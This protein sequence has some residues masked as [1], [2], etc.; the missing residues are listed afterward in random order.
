MT[1]KQTGSGIFMHAPE[2][3]SGL[4]RMSVTER[5]NLSRI[6]VLEK[7][8]FDR[9][10]RL[11]RAS[12][13]GIN[14]A[15]SDYKDVYAFFQEASKDY[16]SDL[17]NPYWAFTHDILKFILMKFITEHFRDARTTHVF[18]AG[19]GT[20]NWSRFV[21]SL[22]VSMHGIM[23]DMNANMLRVA[24][25]KL[26]QVHN[27]VRIVEG[28]LEV[29]SD[30]PSQRSNLVLCM[31]NVIGLGRNTELILHNL[32]TYLEDDGLAFIMAMNKYHAFNFTRQFRDET[33]VL[34]VVHDGTVKFKTDMPEIFCYTPEEFEKILRD[35]GFEDVTILGFPVTVYPSIQD[36]KL[37]RMDTSI[38]QL[39]D[40]K[41]RAGLLA[42][43]KKLCLYPELAYRGGSSLIAVC[44]KKIVAST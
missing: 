32:C 21:L 25:P 38:L 1:S 10:M 22:G 18:D 34:R 30:F 13:A 39:K 37:L 35:A 24:K 16:D 3:T 36:T 9:Q 33:E 12:E 6:A 11:L 15:R 19:A 20:G 43:E 44:K 8:S 40:S 41:V 5:L 28:N 31:H 17:V 42:L 7:V 23:F 14:F 2:A 29:L 26:V 4:F 27:N